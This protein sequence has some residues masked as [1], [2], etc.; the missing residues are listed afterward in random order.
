VYFVL[1][2]AAGGSRRKGLTDKTMTVDP[3]ALNA[4]KQISGGNLPIVPYY[5]REQ[6]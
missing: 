6:L 2:Q 4:D 1:N 3:F 5:A